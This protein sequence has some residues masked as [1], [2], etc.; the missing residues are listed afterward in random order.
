MKRVIISGYP[1]EYDLNNGYLSASPH[2]F[3]HLQNDADFEDLKELLIKCKNP[4]TIITS[5][6]KDRFVEL[7]IKFYKISKLI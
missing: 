2:V 1:V 4:D 5:N 6:D 3:Q 7:L